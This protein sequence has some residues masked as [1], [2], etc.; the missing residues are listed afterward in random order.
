MNTHD[1]T[2]RYPPSSTH[3]CMH[4]QT[5]Q[6][7]IPAPSTPPPSPPPPSLKAH[8]HTATHAHTVARCP[9]VFS[10]GWSDETTCDH[11]RQSRR[12]KFSSIV[13]YIYMLVNEWDVRAGPWVGYAMLKTS[14]NI[15]Y[16]RILS[17]HI[18]YSHNIA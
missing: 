2:S 16:Y 4:G 12:A 13:F 1:P 5:C 10:A 6:A 9:G 17:H 15:T 11:A 18:S 14:F 8:P 7:H 3:T